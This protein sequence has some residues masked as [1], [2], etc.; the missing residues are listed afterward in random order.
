LPKFKGCLKNISRMD[1]QY[2]NI[3]NTDVNLLDPQLRLLHEVVIE[4]ILDAG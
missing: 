2:F 3:S 4:S 1:A